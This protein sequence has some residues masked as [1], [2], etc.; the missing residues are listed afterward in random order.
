MARDS[1]HGRG[2]SESPPLR[3]PRPPHLTR[4]PR[5]RDE[6]PLWRNWADT[7]RARPARWLQPRDVAEVSA[8]VITAAQEGLR[9]KAVGSG[10]SFSGIAVAPDVLLDLARMDRVRRV[11]TVTGLV[12]VEAGL[13]L[14]RLSPWLWRAGLAMTNLGDIDR[15]SIAGAISTGTHGTGLGFGT[16]ASQVV[17]L[18]LVTADGAVV[19]CSADERADLFNA[20]RVG[21]GAFGVITAVTLQCVPAFALHAFE[22]A[23][24][25]AEALEMLIDPVQEAEHLGLFW[26]PHTDQV[27]LK[28]NR[29]LS[30]GTAPVPEPAW[31]ALLN[32]EVL[33]NAALG[34]IAGTSATVPRLIRSSN[35]FCTRMVGHREYS[36][37]SYRVFASRRRVVFRESEFGVPLE[38]L[39]GAFAEIRAWLERPR[40]EIGFP[41]EIRVGT[42]EDSWLSMAHG[43]PTAWIS[44]QTHHRQDHESLLRAIGDICL[45][46]SGRPH[47]GKIH[48]LDA[49]TLAPLYPRF[50]DALTVRDQVDPAR[51]FA[52]PYLDRVLG[53]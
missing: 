50:A 21:L 2:R 35:R 38:A 16:L 29:R 25:L 5:H 34:L 49:A 17:G 36:D 12:T 51:R 41:M 39:P 11:D 47:W 24:P 31:R 1:E 43:R 52:N 7:E 27:L 46:Y 32:D 23:V 8:A 44:A 18:E 26:F 6:G 40:H 30:P 10:H 20:A 45:G 37:R 15:Q 14:Y 28:S 13:Q 42:G 19:T 48:Y 9:V 33:Q 3:L 4:R 53:R 22:R